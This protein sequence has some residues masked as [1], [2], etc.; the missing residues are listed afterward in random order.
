MV[1]VAYAIL[2]LILEDTR[3]AVWVQYEKEGAIWRLVKLE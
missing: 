3:I 1:V 2:C